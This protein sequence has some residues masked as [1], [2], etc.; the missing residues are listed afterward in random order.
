ME[1]IPHAKEFLG[2]ASTQVLINQLLLA[3]VLR[4]DK[5]VLA[6]ST[7]EIDNTGGHILNLK[8]DPDGRWFKLIAEKKQ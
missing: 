3:L 2:E 7:T 1:T 8:I 6:M 4:A 5:G